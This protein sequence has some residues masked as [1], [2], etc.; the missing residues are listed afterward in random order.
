ML[1]WQIVSSGLSCSGLQKAQN[2][3]REAVWVCVLCPSPR[4]VKGCEDRGRVR[5]R[6]FLLSSCQ[7]FTALAILNARPY[8][9]LEAEGS[10][11]AVL[12][13]GGSV[14]GITDQLY[15][16]TTITRLSLTVVMAVV[17]VRVLNATL[18]TYLKSYNSGC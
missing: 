14:A 13:D 5:E 18:Y 16:T 6:A 3:T 15:F 11:L 12:R 9:P 2:A 4:R 10:S 17:V 1:A 8:G 7:V